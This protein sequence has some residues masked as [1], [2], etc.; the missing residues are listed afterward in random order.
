MQSVF[1]PDRPH[2]IPETQ[3]IRHGSFSV[4]LFSGCFPQ[5]LRTFYKTKLKGIAAVI[6]AAIPFHCVRFVVGNYILLSEIQGIFLS[7]GK[8]LQKSRRSSSLSRPSKFFVPFQKFS[9]PTILQFIFWC[10]RMTLNIM[11]AYHLRKRKPPIR[12][13]TYEKLV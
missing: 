8:M 5:Q 11:A 3:N 9:R 4:P 6:Q 13:D 12:G 2:D 7:K 1:H 10:G